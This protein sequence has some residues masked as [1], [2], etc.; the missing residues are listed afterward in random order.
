M[1]AERNVQQRKQWLQGLSLLLILAMLLTA[2]MTPGEGVTAVEE[3]TPTPE[4]AAEAAPAAE[5]GAETT[6]AAGGIVE[7]VVV[8]EEPSAAAAVTRL[9]VGEIDLYAF[10]VTDPEVYQTVSQS[11]DL[12]YAQ[13]FGSTSELTFNVA[14]PVF[15][16]TGKLN[17]FAVPRIREAMN[18]LVDR[19][20]I[21]QEIHGGLAL[22]KFFAI[23]SSFPDYA[24]L[25]D[26]A[27]PL[28]LQ[29]SYDLER[30]REVISE[31]MEALGAELVDSKWQYNGE[32]VEI[33]FLIRTEDER[34]D[35]GDYVSNQLEDIGFTVMRDY[36]AA[37]EAS[38]IWTRT[39]PN[40]GLFH[41]YTGGW[42]TTVVSRDQSANFDFYY[43][44]R[45][46]SFPLWQAYTPTEAFDT[47]SDRLA[48]RDFQTLE[49]RRDLF[50]QA[51]ELSLQDSSR[52][53]L[54]DRLSISPYRTDISVAADLAGGINGSRLWP[55]TIREGGD[56]DGSVTVAMP[57]I[58]PE[59]WNP[60]DGTNWIY[61]QMLI[62]ATGDLDL[63]PDP[64]TGLSWPQRIERAEI[65]I[66]EGLPVGKTHDWV[67]LQFAPT[68]EVPE[69]AWI[70]WDPVA[71]RFI[72]VGEKHPDGIT[73]NSKSVTY[74]PA[75]LY[76]IQWHDGSNL[77]LADMVLSL[78]LTFDRGMEG[79][80]IY[81][82]AQV[83]SLEAFKESFRGVRIVQT[84]PLVI[85]T[86]SDVYLLDAEQ[87]VAGLFPA[88]GQGS[89]AWHT[90]GLGI[91]AE[92]E[93]ELA[94]S[95]DKADALQVEWMN[96][97]A[98]PSLEI[99][100]NHLSEAGADGYIPYAPT[101]GEYITADEVQAR[102]SN[103]QNW[104]DE[105]GHF[106]VG[107]GPYYLEAAFP[108]EGNVQLLRTPDYPDAADKWLRFTEPQIA[109][110]E[111]D[112]GGRVT[113]G[114]EA[115]FDV[116]V[117]FKDAPYAVDGISEVKYLVFGATGELVE[118]GAAEAVEDGLWQVVLSTEQTAALEAGANRLEI[119]VVPTAVSI[120]TFASV[121]FITV[122]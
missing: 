15:E 6:A 91:L 45:G 30:A 77:S 60:L 44:P 22:P 89:G 72:T 48:R 81:D 34:K 19:T 105:K 46:L 1:K 13:S 21:A 35:I 41:I 84:D 3:P 97:I 43:T 42:V 67:D 102:W 120:P 82:E 99:L 116:L 50:A 88:Y 8:V 119:A 107:T 87:N 54:V 20:Y 56:A 114:E 93:Q 98:G 108:V 17:P 112:G 66:R 73:A 49:E 96:Y 52:I 63:M 86:Y 32:P 37:A 16:G 31:E 100:Q 76:N 59:P 64:F 25:V 65:V 39:D 9:G 104:Y 92:S 69:D 47:L 12:A 85:E 113:I 28:E 75:D 5:A 61:D 101:L 122:P 10:A 24:R 2:C 53:W 80:A 71:Q 29:Y 7:E 40:E 38:P 110:V 14:G 74:Y 111:I 4:A 103:L 33:I 109:T 58:L 121:E 26:V 78:I 95:A 68:I 27:R 118:T 117:S 83:P 18:W 55:H 79:S 115:T 36:R 94:F 62:R 57:S 90:L 51:L 11:S 70:D 23:T 106:W